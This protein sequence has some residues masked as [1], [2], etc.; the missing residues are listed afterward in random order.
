MKPVEPT[1][2]KDRENRR[3][4]IEH[5]PRHIGRRKCDNSFGFLK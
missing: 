5:P 2:F 1:V 4:I 3:L